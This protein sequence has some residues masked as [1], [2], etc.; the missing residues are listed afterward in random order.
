MCFYDKKAQIRFYFSNLIDIDNLLKKF[1]FM[2]HLLGT[3]VK[4][5]QSS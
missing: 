4:V 2:R 1:Y 5:S 3:E